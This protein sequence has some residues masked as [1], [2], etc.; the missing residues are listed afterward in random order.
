MT[1]AKLY[2]TW[3]AD[4]HVEG[5]P[6]PDE[7]GLFHRGELVCVLP[8]LRAYWPPPKKKP[9]EERNNEQIEEVAPPWQAGTWTK[10]GK[11]W[12]RFFRAD[13]V[14]DWIAAV[15]PP[16]RE[17]KQFVTHVRRLLLGDRA[18][19]LAGW[20]VPIDDWQAGRGNIFERRVE[21]I[22]VTKRGESLAWT[23]RW[24]WLPDAMRHWIREEHEGLDPV[25]TPESDRAGLTRYLCEGWRIDDDGKLRRSSTA[26][27]WGPS[28]ARIPYRLHDAP[29]RL[30]LGA[31]LQARAIPLEKEDEPCDRV[32][33][34]G[35]EPP[36]RNLRVVFSAF[37]GWTHEDAMVISRSAAEKLVRG[38]FEVRLRIPAVVSCVE[39]KKPGM[40][41]SGVPLARGFIDLFA[42]GWRRHEA[43]AFGAEDG[44]VE[45]ALSGAKTPVDAEL[46]EV[47]RHPLETVRWRESITL[48][49]KP[50][51]AA[52]GLGDKLS[53][54]HGIKGV[55]SKVLE[56]EAMPA[57][58]TEHAEVILSPVG[59]IRRGAM[60]QLREA[61]RTAD[62]SEPPRSGTIF[63][64]R[65]AQDAAP[66]LR[67]RGV[68]PSAVRGQRYGEMEFWALM[69]H[70]VP[71]IAQELLS[72]ERS[73]AGW[74]KREAG[75]GRKDSK[76]LATQALN[77]YLAVIGA[78]IE[79]GKLLPPEVEDGRFVVR[80]KPAIHAIPAK[81]RAQYKQALELLDDATW[82][83][84]HDGLAR[85]DLP[86][87]ITA[88]FLRDKDVVLC[89]VVCD[90]VYVIPPWLR[91]AG[92][93]WRHRITQAYI[94]LIYF[95]VNGSDARGRRNLQQLVEACV[96]LA[97]GDR[98]GVVAF[99]RREVLGRRLTR[100][101][102]A[103]IVPRPDLRID[104]ILLPRVAA[105]TLFDGLSERAR[106]LVLVNRNP[107]LHR[108]GLLAMRPVID[109]SNAPVFG[110]PL[111]VLKALGADF[112][113]DQASVV[114]LE[115]DEALAQAERLLPG[116]EELRL[117][118]FRRDTPAF[119]LLKELSMPNAEQD[120]A[121][122]CTK[123]QEEWCAA[124]AALLKEAFTGVG[125]GWDIE[126]TQKA[127]KEKENDELWKGLLDEETWQERAEKV[128]QS[129]YEVR[130]KGQL[131]GILRR[132]LYRRI[133]KDEESFWRSVQALQAVTEPIVQTALS[134]KTGKG[135]VKDA[136]NF[137]KNPQTGKT[138]L[139]ELE[140]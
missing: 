136:K 106:E 7:Q 28:T 133:F 72:L 47:R 127:L 60:G 77:R 130:A 112:D 24:Q 20:L 37:G 104:Q 54:R 33:P 10:L 63:V 34:S 135:A 115:T 78:R 134:V 29:R 39:V 113:G 125:D 107:T 62:A 13:Q 71:E 52:V 14:L 41:K 49:L 95:L 36:G 56:D 58:G 108:R 79:E 123:P 38:E 40:V 102:R 35:W 110:L 103:V 9:K 89:E 4:H 81:T 46:L 21:S 59:I 61:S 70:G 111:G 90:A 92:E 118:P 83:R 15:H 65:Q 16:A 1:N 98:F 105:D 48:R 30:M 85:I 64:M 124:H 73:T 22:R 76:K 68:K 18:A 55:V 5:L 66:R 128:M 6:S 86:E 57:A 11:G 129:I 75:L 87:P 88:R 12:T 44:W 137:F 69:A 120:L 50:L 138:H 42:L 26:N 131:G 45:V 84:K 99:L 114:A 116:S 126:M 94:D 67:V 121:R 119:P 3:F 91:P 93:S 43:R 17:E 2:A 122:D 96:R 117:D 80:R 140:E 101:A 132:E 19:R 51:R 23:R 109:E 31:S 53:T 74:M 139:E 32:D 100:S 97:L 8:Y 27:A 82:F 25:H